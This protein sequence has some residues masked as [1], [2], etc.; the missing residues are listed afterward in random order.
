MIHN[1]VEPDLYEDIHTEW[2]AAIFALAANIRL[3]FTYL[4]LFPFVLRLFRASD[5]VSF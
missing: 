5:L 2:I 3:L 1:A 4:K